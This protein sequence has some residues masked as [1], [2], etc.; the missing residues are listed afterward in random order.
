MISE[1]KY[2]GYSASPSDYES[3]DGDLASVVGLVPEDGALKPIPNPKPLFTLE[4]GQKVVVLH[5]TSAFAHYIIQDSANNLYWRDENGV[6]ANPLCNLGA[7]DIYQITTIGN[8]IVALCSDGMHYMLWKADNN[9]YVYLGNKIPECPISFGLQGEN[10]LYSELNDGTFTIRY[11]TEDATAPFN[12]FS[13]ENKV[14]ITSQ[15]LSKVN[16]F[17]AQVSTDE[18]KFIFPFFVRYAYRLYDESLTHHSAPILMLPCTNTNPVVYASNGE[19]GSTSSELD[20]YA[21][22]TSLDYMPLISSAE[23]RELNNWSDIV[24]SVDIFISAPIYTYDQSGTCD[25]F[26]YSP[27]SYFFGRFIPKGG[28]LDD[29][30]ISGVYQKWL[31]LS[32]HS[33]DYGA[34]KLEWGVRLPS[35]PSSEIEGKIK[36][37]ST[38]YFLTSIDIKDLPSYR[39]EIK[40]EDGVLGSLVAREVMTDDYQTHDT[41]IPSFAQAYNNRLNIANIER[42]LFKGYDTAAQVCYTNGWIAYYGTQF[43]PD[44][45]LTSAEATIYTKVQ[46]DKTYTLRNECS[47]P[48]SPRPQDYVYLYYPDI[49]AK[50]VTLTINGRGKSLKM[51]PHNMLNGSAYFAGFK[52]E[53]DAFN[54]SVPLSDSNPVI[55]LPNKIYTSEVNNP[56]Y[57]PLLGINTIGTGDIIGISTAAKAL[58]E[59]QFG[60]FPLYAFATDGVWAL[61]VSSTGSY[62]AKQPITRDVC[63]GRES[64]TQIDSA[65]LFATARG[66]MLLSGSQS[67]C[68][69]DILDSAE[70]FKLSS[71]PQGGKLLTDFARLAES[72]ADY[73]P[74]VEFIAGCRMIYDYVQ[75][76]IV[77]INPN[78]QYAY[79]YSLESKAWGIIPSNLKSVVNSY[80]EA[81]AMDGYNRLV[82]MSKPD[83]TTEIPFF[84][85]T[86][87]LK[88]EADVLKTIDTIIQRGY[89]KRGHVK[90]ALYGSRDMF[91]WFLVASST[92]QYLR[93]F[94][95]TP[96]K[97]FRIAVMGALD[98]KETITG[99][100]IEY[101][102][103]QTNQL[104]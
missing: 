20:I 17:V 87:P 39:T 83:T 2:K 80:P 5:K 6:T 40:I 25:S 31:S 48:L 53:D 27:V 55:S 63:L 77:I 76:R 26:D 1:I 97:Y 4:A 8:T 38:F 3:L 73:L 57:F 18:N 29:A 47:T 91:D 23:R 11:D 93:G 65:V 104:R 43:N 35:F 13:D 66:I 78:C 71:L 59:G 96:Y 10:K 95:G 19:L 42:Q 34:H 44:A 9:D 33:Y 28:G 21:I 12:D 51:T 62:S 82:D 46:G 102:P 68:I 89:F 41:L 36:D 86:R 15:V 30:K 61:E 54:A 64:I 81:L 37:C 58:S 74:F 24:K 85:V 101:T 103:R 14:S 45:D 94:R 60:Q 70:P 88:I 67:I 22:A 72:N 98:N 84:F 92:D 49:A 16:K 69:S 90:M 7:A 79:V 50:E 99:A 52:N 75:Q 56:F 32:L 100:T